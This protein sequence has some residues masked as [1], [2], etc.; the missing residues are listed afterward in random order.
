MLTLMVVD[1]PRGSLVGKAG[2]P[3]YLL[4]HMRC[5]AVADIA[6][7]PADLTGMRIWEASRVFGKYLRR[8]QVDHNE[9]FAGLS[10][11]ELGSGSGPYLAAHPLRRVWT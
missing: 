10:A 5:N 2:E 3:F 1:Q 6:H 7:R 4:T 11:C 9:T 8:R